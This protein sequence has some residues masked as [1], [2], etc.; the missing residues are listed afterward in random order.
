MCIRDRI[1]T[2]DKTIIGSTVPRYSYSFNLGVGYKGIRLSAF[3]Q[4]VGKAGDF[5]YNGRG[6][7]YD[8]NNSN[9]TIIGNRCV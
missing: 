5:E 4:G 3:L 1:T 2:D 8:Y 9:Y 6:A 7:T